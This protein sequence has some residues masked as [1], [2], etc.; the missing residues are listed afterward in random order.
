MHSLS[1]FVKTEQESSSAHSR[2]EIAKV[3]ICEVLPNNTYVF[4]V[5]ARKAMLTACEL[6]SHTRLHFTHSLDQIR[7]ASPR[8]QL[9]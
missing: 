6:P 7:S 5:P 4:A 8:F 2:G 3:L 1:R 9:P